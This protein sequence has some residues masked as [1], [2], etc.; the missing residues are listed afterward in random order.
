MVAQLERLLFLMSKELSRACNR[1]LSLKQQ[2]Q[3]HLGAGEVKAVCRDIVTAYNNGKF[4]DR[5]L[6]F[7]IIRDY[8][9]A[10]VRDNPRSVRWHE[11]VKVFFSLIDK[12]G[13]NR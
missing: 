11:S 2:L 1:K 3:D 12:R 4:E 9:S 6:L 8:A 7:D 13:G 10:A 5:Q